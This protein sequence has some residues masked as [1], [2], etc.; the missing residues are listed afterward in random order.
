MTDIAEMVKKTDMFELAQKTNYKLDMTDD[1]KD[2]VAELDEHF[3]KIG[4]TGH[5]RDHEISA[6]LRKVVNQEIYEAPDEILDLIFERGT[7]GEFDDYQGTI[8][9]PENTLVVYEAGREGTVPNSYLDIGELQPTWRNF[10][11]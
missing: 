11:V 10:Q 4:E 7:I 3:R 9:P 6:F 1:E 2:I 5:D 8:M